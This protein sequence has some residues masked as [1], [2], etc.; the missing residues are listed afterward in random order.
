MSNDQ[1]QIVFEQCGDAGCD[2]IVSEQ[3]RYHL[4]SAGGQSR[5]PFDSLD[6]AL[7]AGGLPNVTGATRSISCSALPAE[8]LAR[9]AKVDGP[10]GHPVNI[11]GRRWV[12]SRDRLVRSV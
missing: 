12:I 2:R 8:E 9:R 3:G 10:P 1:S 6:E 5:G 4:R 11:N 7:R